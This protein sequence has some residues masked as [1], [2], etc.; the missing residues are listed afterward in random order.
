[1]KAA[2]M[3]R[4]AESDKSDCFVAG[5]RGSVELFAHFSAIC[6]ENSFPKSGPLLKGLVSR[7]APSSSP[8]R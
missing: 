1:M 2:N 5:K 6:A 4:I 7:F 8:R 3:E